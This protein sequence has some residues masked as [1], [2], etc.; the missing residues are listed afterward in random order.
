MEEEI[1]NKQDTAGAAT[2]PFASRQECDA[3]FRDS[4]YA[5]RAHAP[6]TIRP[7]FNVWALLFGA[8]WCIYRKLYMPAAVYMVLVDITMIACAAT[9]AGHGTSEDQAA[10]AMMVILLVFRLILA[11]SINSVY[12]ERG[13]RTIAR[14]RAAHAGDPSAAMESIT[15][16]GG[17]SVTA[18]AIFG[19]CS[20][21]L[22]LWLQR[23]G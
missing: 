21:L 17:T 23:G 9:M 18:V 6:A 1:G 10:Q 11:K 15:R 14:L 13:L 19:F 8:Y 3:F 4:F 22:N 7:G 12:I 16:A 5:E 2:R 20:A